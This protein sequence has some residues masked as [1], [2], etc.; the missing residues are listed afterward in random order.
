VVLCCVAV[1]CS[2]RLCKFG[3]Q[4]GFLACK[5]GTNAFFL[6]TLWPSPECSATHCV[7]HKLA[8]QSDSHARAFATSHHVCASRPITG[9]AAPTSRE[10]IKAGY[11]YVIR[12]VLVMA[13]HLRHVVFASAVDSQPKPMW[14]H[15]LRSFK[16][17]RSAWLLPVIYFSP[18]CN[19]RP[20]LLERS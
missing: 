17:I 6:A 19:S 16:D 11:G 14:A 18:A 20:A 8:W 13:S 10:H 15:V 1:S 4:S 12:C 5:V 3:R 9:C 7:A 2:S